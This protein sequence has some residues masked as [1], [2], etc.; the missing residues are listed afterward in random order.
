MKK[1]I[2]KQTQ[3]HKRREQ[4]LARRRTRVI[5]RLDQANRSRYRI[6]AE[7][8]GP[9]LNNQQGLRYELADRT[10]GMIYGGAPLMVRLAKHVGLDREINRRVEVLKMHCPYHES[11]HV[12]NLAV[13]ALCGGTRLQDIEM[14]RNDEVFLDALGV[15]AIPDPTTAGDF[16]RRFSENDIRD[17]IGAINAARINVWKEQD[18]GF[19][20]EA[21]VDFDGVIVETTGE[22]K[23]GMDISYDGRWGYHPLLVSLANT[24]EPLSIVNRSANRPSE[25]GAWKEADDMIPYLRGA[26]FR[27]IRL[28][29]DTKFS[30]TEHLDRWDTDNV[31]FQFGY[32]ENSAVKS[33]AEAFPDEKWEELERSP[34]YQVA[35]VPRRRPENV[36]AKIV[37]QREYLNLELKSEEVAEFDYQPVACS[38]TYRMVVVRK[39]ISREKGENVLFD[40]IRYFYY[41]TNDLESPAAE[42]VFGCNDRCNQENLI[43]QLAGGLRGLAA[44]VDNLLSNWA[45]MVMASLA[46]SLKAWAALLQPVSSRWREKHEGE[47]QTILRMEFKQFVDHFIRI[48]CQV[49]LQ[50]RR[51]IHRVLNWNPWLSNFFRLSSILRC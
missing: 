1:K 29:G 9:V 50:G 23:Q 32:Q 41:I 4:K 3:R 48:P 15:S 31:I 49:V 44:P 38:R 16:C 12:L 45:Y 8:D 18:H 17:L 7:L 28:R 21:V 2:T 34:K 20:D 35:S 25:E 42:I 14:R 40:E 33:R 13:N 36:K 30:Q 47:R 37:R 46:W 39:N 11:D 6:A 27:S 43:A 51:V 19:F 24:S 22:C 10:R 26:G 5:K